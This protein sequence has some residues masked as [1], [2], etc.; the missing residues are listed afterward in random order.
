MSSIFITGSTDGLGRMAAQLLIHR[1]HAVYLHARNASRAED[2]RRNLPG[3]ADVLTADLSNLG[4]ARQLAEKANAVGRFDAVIHN[5]AVLGTDGR[6][7]ATVNTLSPYVLTCL[8][9]RPE[10]LV[11][12]SSND[13][14]WGRMQLDELE[15]HAPDI[16]YADTKLQIAAF[17][18]AVARHWPE[19]SSNAVDPGWVATKMG[20]AGAP[21]DLQQGHLTQAWLAEGAD[22]ATGHSGEYFYHKHGADL[23]DVARDPQVQDALL[24]T[25]ARATGIKF[26]EA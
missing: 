2:A 12:L 24:D 13:H 16:R 17:A 22:G 23:K 14:S 1:G 11:Y 6:T 26:P 18:L 3:A 15:K 7:M 10:R 20:G 21:D 8:M 5:A 9:E 25:C 4:A 19:V